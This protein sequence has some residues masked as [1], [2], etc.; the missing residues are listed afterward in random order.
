MQ[1]E[2]ES[3]RR[4]TLEDILDSEN[5]SQAWKQVRGNRG[6]AG[7]DGMEVGDFPDFYAKHW[8]MIRRKLMDGSYSPSPVRRVLIPK[9]KGQF[10]AL[11]IPTVLDRLIQQSIAQVLTPHYETIFSDS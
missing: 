8:E 7:V 4:M 6:A 1:A 5:L 9:D 10:R 3:S 2:P 11:G